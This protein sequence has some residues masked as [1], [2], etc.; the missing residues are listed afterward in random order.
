MA[1]CNNQCLNI[2]NTNSF[3][4]LNHINR[5]VFNCLVCLITSFLLVNSPSTCRLFPGISG[6][7]IVFLSLI[8]FNILKVFNWAVFVLIGHFDFFIIW[9]D[10]VFFFVLPCTTLALFASFSVFCWQQNFVHIWSTCIID[11]YPFNFNLLFY[12]YLISL[13]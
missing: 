3:N 12:I 6:F 9:S 7:S 1:V 8:F 4:W 10:C 2:R 11:Q 13:I 5:F